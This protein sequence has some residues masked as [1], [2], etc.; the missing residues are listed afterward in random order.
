MIQVLTFSIT[1][2]LKKYR[3]LLMKKNLRNTMK[4]TA[5]MAFLLLLGACAQTAETGRLETMLG[6][7]QSA[8]DQAL[9]AARDAQDTADSALIAAENASAKAD[10]AQQSADEALNSVAECC[11]KVDRMFE[12]AM[13]K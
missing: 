3:G 2:S 5:V 12:K 6:E 13:R 7:A 10:T 4:L 1:L 11:A 9:S 8:A